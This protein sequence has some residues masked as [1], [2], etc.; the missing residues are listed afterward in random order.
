MKRSAAR[1]ASIAAFA[2]MLAS[3]GGAAAQSYYIDV[4]AAVRA[5]EG[6]VLG[7][8]F[9]EIVSPSGYARVRELAYGDAIRDGR[10]FAPDAMFDVLLPRLATGRID[11]Y[12][13]VRGHRTDGS[14]AVA[15]VRF[16]DEAGWF[17]TVV[18][19]RI[20]EGYPRDA[21][22]LDEVEKNER[23]LHAQL[24][25][26]VYESRRIAG[27]LGPAL[28]VIVR[29]RVADPFYPYAA[30]KVSGASRL[31][32]LSIDRFIVRGDVLLEVGMVIPRPAE[33]AEQA[34]V[35]F[36]RGESDRFLSG[37]GTR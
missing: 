12:R 36:A 32:S 15:H 7:E 17:A 18:A 27:P 14:P 23:A 11:V 30:A 6:V 16:R 19:T 2:F 1:R 29:N 35:D 34:F 26:P 13:A 37:L 22:L 20:P 21:R 5:S 9:S 3:A 4:A 10:Y 33:M 24:D 8:F 28:E 25:P 31:E